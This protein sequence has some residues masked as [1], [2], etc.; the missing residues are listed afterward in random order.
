M[1]GVAG[2]RAR[3]VDRS[4][5]TRP[6]RHGG[7]IAQQSSA[8]CSQLISRRAKVL[9]IILTS[10]SESTGRST[11]GSSSASSS[12]GCTSTSVGMHGSSRVAGARAL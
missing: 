7:A 12:V 8:R 11:A 4:T 3:L 1:A 2:R 10:A 5:T 9:L 6:G